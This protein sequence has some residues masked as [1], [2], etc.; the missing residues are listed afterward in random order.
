M[1]KLPVVA[2]IGRPNVGKS[3]FFNR[4]VGRRQAIVSEVAGTTR[5]QIM[6]QIEADGMRYLLVD[7][8]G[9]GGGSLDSDFEDD[10]EGQSLLALEHADLIL[11][12]VNGREELTGSD[13]AVAEVLR[14]KRKRHVPVFLVIAKCDDAEKMD[15][16][17]PRY[18]ELG[19]AES[20]FPISAAHGLG[21]DDL[22]DAIVERLRKMHFGETRGEG[23][24]KGEEGNSDSGPPR[25]AIVG[26]PNVGKSSIVNA[27]MSEEQ[28]KSAPR[29]ISPFPGT[30]RDSTDTVIRF[31]GKDYVFIDTAG[32]RKQARVERGLELF[33]VLRT[34]Q[35]MAE[36]DVTVLVL[37][38]TQEIGKQDKHIAG[39]A[40]EQGTGLVL[41]VNKV[42][43]LS[44]EE[45]ELLR[46]RLARAFLFCRWAP[47][48]FTS[49]KTREEL[50][51]L[52]EL[53]HA[54]SENRVRR[55]TT[56]MVNR[57]FQDLSEKNQTM[58]GGKLPFKYVTQ[59]DV[60]PPTFAIFL[61]DPRRLHVSSLRFIEKK[62]RE[63]F[64]FEGTPVRW[65][66]KGGIRR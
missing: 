19:I 58:A 26:R 17:L 30:T 34:L 35:A 61:K 37:D 20:V 63:V 22:Q 18:Y 8:G 36:A 7:T 59:V 28:R 47:I 14:K 41:V 11:F 52:F 29:L 55:I 60:S 38:A 15:E 51:H 50:P 49:A 43:L 25:I 44:T 39:L 53:I 2:I 3:T 21:I 27:L 56:S 12:V 5:D 64:P 65:V 6:T 24:G 57:L 48:L 9:M 54:V 16:A 32:L 10:V 46:S 13:Y 42:D 1:A 4:L 62:L 66:K 40:I 31:K 33:S 23:E 45:K